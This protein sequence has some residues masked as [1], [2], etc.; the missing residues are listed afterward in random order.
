VPLFSPN[1]EAELL[2]TNEGGI[3]QLKLHVLSQPAEHTLVLGACP[4]DARFPPHCELSN[5]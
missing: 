1:P 4:S 3:I 5:S 2:A